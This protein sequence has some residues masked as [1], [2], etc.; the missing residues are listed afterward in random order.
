MNSKIILVSIISAFFVMTNSTEVKSQAVDR[1]TVEP[2]YIWKLED[3]YTTDAD[4]QKD[5]EK[6]KSDLDGFDAYKGKLNTS[7]KTL[8]EFLKFGSDFY[9]KFTKVY[10]Y[11]SMKSDQDISNTKYMGMLQELKQLEPTIGAKTSF[12]E[13]ELLAM[14]KETIDRFISEQKDLGVYKMYLHELL[15]KKEHLLSEKEEKIL[16][17]ASSIS[18]SPY[19][20]YKVFSNTELPYPQAKLSNGE[21]VKLDQSGFSKYRTSANRADRELVFH[22]FWSA[23]KKFQGTLTEQLL[24]NVNADIFSA[25]AR[26]YSSCLESSLDRNNIPVSVYH[27]LIDNVNKNLPVFYRYLSLRKRM[28]GLDTLKYSD[29]YASVVKDIELKYSYDEAQ[30]IIVEA[31]SPL[32]KDYQSVI[33]KAFNERWL[34]VYPT[35]GKRSGA[36]SQGAVYDVHPYMLLNYNGEYNDVS[37]AAHELGHTMQSYYSNKTQPYPLADYPIFTAEVASTF[38]EDLLN[39]YMISKIADD[40]IRL[41]L[42]MSRLDGF[43]GTLFR[44]TQFAE[45][46]LRI[47]EKAEAGEP[48]TSDVLNKIYGDIL[49]KYYGHDKG[50]CV[51]DDLYSIEWAYIPHFYYNFYVYQYATSFT[52]SSALAEKVLS[53]EKGSLEKYMA[54]ISAGGSDYPIELLKKAGVDMTTSEPFDKAIASMNH[55]MDEIEAILKKQGK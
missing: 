47:H 6:V 44:Q 43:K 2:K 22:T 37:T 40:N 20:I 9:Q 29:M 51:V 7:S 14:G 32:G 39:H 8:L 26:N 17:L 28:M 55:I 4:W 10:C 50:V 15:R 46:E 34:D 25:R 35:T 30:K 19:S 21:T 12:A 5:K 23:M 13:P 52:A 18:G 27:S 42:L 41:S 31:L 54:F 48:L 11:A 45:F 49:K 24:A 1:S 38:N 3:I 33:K 16:A 53:N 36:Y